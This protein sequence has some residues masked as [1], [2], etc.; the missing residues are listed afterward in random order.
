MKV[1]VEMTEIDGAIVVA[2]DLFKDARGFFQ[3]AFRAD[4]FAKHG[5]PTSYFQLNHSGSVKNTVRGLH[6]QWDPPMGKLMRVIHGQAFLVAVDIRKNSPTLGKFVTR[7]LSADDRK[8][9]WAPASFAR[10][11]AVLSDFCEIEYLTTGIYNGAGESGIRWNDPA[12]GVPWPVKEPILSAKDTTAQT[13]SEWLA[14]PESEN[15]KL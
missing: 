1:E 13:L 3:E 2:P 15:F 12:I 6:F 7:I 4:E 5:L 14:R 11:F 8:W 9:L 10:G